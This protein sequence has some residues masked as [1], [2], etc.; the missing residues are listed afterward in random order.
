[1]AV[2][3]H[4][5]EVLDAHADGL[6]DVDAGLNGHDVAGLQRGGARRGEPRA[7][8]HLEPDAV[9]EAVAEV[10][11]VPGRVDDLARDGIDVA[12]GRPRAH[13]GQRLLLSALDELVDLA[14]AEVKLA[15]GERPRAVRAVAVELAPP[16]DDD[17]GALGDGHVAR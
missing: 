14:V 7:L 4:H 6:A 17:Q 13:R 5:D 1:M 16:V 15:G 2:F 9:P 12:A 10:L 3:G 11:G 8:V